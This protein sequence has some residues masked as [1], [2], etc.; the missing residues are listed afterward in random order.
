MNKK[1]IKVLKVVLTSVSITLAFTGYVTNNN[2]IKASNIIYKSDNVDLNKSEIGSIN[3]QHYFINMIIRNNNYGVISSEEDGKKVLEKVGEFYINNCKIDKKDILDVDV[4]TNVQYEKCIK[5]STYV[6]SIDNIA[7]KIVD[8]NK[9]N[10]ILEINMK[11]K[12]T[13]KEEIKPGVKTVKRDDMYLGEVNQENGEVGYKE[14]VAQISY[15]NGAKVGEEVLEEKTLLDSK[16]AIIYKGCKSPISDKVA[17]LDHP[18][19]GGVV[20]SRF[21]YRWGKSH[22]GIDIAHNTGDPVYCAFDG[23]VTECGYV[24][25]YGN[26]ISIEHEGNIQTIYAHLSAIQT[27]IGAQV[28]KGDLIGKVGSTGNSTGPHLHFEVRVNGVPIN[29]EGYIKI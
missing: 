24:N 19:K 8:D 3:G 28:K 12:E 15:T 11:C 29:P 1:I 10:N 7:K 18:T 5:E 26:K 17:F 13:R 2:S 20:T 27:K 25:G 16:D 9:N 14:V 21:G 6:D 4:K 22:N 23:I